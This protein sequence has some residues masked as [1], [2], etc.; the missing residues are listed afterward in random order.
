[1]KNRITK[2]DFEQQLNELPVKEDDLIIGGK[3]RRGNYGTM[4]RRYDPIAF[5]VAYSDE[6]RES[7][8][9]NSMR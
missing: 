3:Q 1:M 2:K 9:R 6:V 4:L 7:A 5:E 8:F